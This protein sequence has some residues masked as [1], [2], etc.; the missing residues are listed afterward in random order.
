MFELY[1]CGY[2]ASQ[3]EARLEALDR[4]KSQIKV[5]R[6]SNSVVTVTPKDRGITYRG[7]K[8]SLLYVPAWIGAV[9]FKDRRISLRLDDS[10]GQVFSLERLPMN[11]GRILLLVS[12]ILLIIAAVVLLLIFN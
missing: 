6:P 1:T 3:K 8:H 10:T 11:W 9:N 2:L 4:T 5:D 7:E 12:F